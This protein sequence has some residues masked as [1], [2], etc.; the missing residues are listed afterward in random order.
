MARPT[1]VITTVA[2]TGA[3]YALIDRKDAWHARVVE[4]WAAAARRVY[5]PASIL[6]EVCYLLATRISADA[7]IALMRSV[8]DGELDVVEH[9]FADHARAHELMT[10]FRD[11]ELGFV[12]A[13]VIAAVK[14][15][16]SVVSISPAPM[17]SA[18][19]PARRKWALVP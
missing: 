17:R 8:R 2:D 15:R 14:W 6:P 10:T 3:I 5:L 9:E 11:M 4:W 13:M 18:A 16:R 12:D 1:R 7:E 19:A